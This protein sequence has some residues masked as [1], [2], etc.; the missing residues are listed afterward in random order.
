MCVVGYGYAAV[1]CYWLLTSLSKRYYMNQVWQPGVARVRYD[2]SSESFA[3]LSLS[4][5][6]T[7]TPKQTLH[8]CIFL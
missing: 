6:H 4:I 3:I 5:P 7:L 8:P 2:I 1:V